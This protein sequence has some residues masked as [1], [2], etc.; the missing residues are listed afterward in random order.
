MR[1]PNPSEGSLPHLN[2]NIIAFR[3]KTNT[4]GTIVQVYHF[5][6][7]KKLKDVK[8]Q[9]PFSFW[10]WVSND[11][12]AVVTKNAVYHLDLTKEAGQSAKI[13][14]RRGNMVGCQIINYTLDPQ[15]KY[16]S[17]SGKSSNS[18][19]VLYGSLRSIIRVTENSVT[20]S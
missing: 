14:D 19:F 11:I 9:E 8:I 4:G 16:A 18:S 1:K 7:Q 12:L 6:E 5:A 10:R 15:G 3:A 20:R 13:V 2:D 17:I